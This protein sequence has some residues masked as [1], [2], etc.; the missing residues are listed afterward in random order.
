MIV[1]VATA[2]GTRDSD[3]SPVVD[4]ATVTQPLSGDVTGLA[5]ATVTWK[6]VSS[7]GHPISGTFAFTAE[8][9][10]PAPSP[11]ETTETSPATPTADP[12]PTP[13]VLPGPPMEV[14]PGIPAFV[15]AI[16]GVLGAAAAGALLYLGVARARARGDGG[17][18]PRGD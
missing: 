17:G 8:G 4:G 10:A 16:I 3:G 1:K 7:D 12:S 11:T 5:D 6:V 15:W 13:T 9:A 18:A 2:N 14:T